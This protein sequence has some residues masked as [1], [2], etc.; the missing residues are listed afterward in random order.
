MAFG[1]VEDETGSAEFVVFPKTYEVCKD[2]LKPNA[3]V[4]MKA[5]VEVREET[6]SLMV[7]KVTVPTQSDLEFSQLQN[8]KEIFIPRD[9]EK[10]TL[11]KLGTLLKS[12]P[13]KEKVVIIIPNGSLP[14]RMVLPYTVAWDEKLEQAIQ[15]LLH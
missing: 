13:G 5:K 12:N 2:L 11:Q 10:T 15:N 1:T 14:E 8:Y 6:I 3:V 7:E 4:L 9:T